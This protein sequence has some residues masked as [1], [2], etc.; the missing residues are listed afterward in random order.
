MVDFIYQYFALASIG[1]LLA[2]IS[3]FYFLWISVIR[4]RYM[5]TRHHDSNDMK[6]TPIPPPEVGGAWPIIGHL[7]QLA[8]STPLFK[9]LGDMADKYGS[10]FMVWF[11][12]YP[13]LVVSSW[14]M[15]KECFT[16]N[17]KF[18][19]S[20]PPTASGKYLGYDFAML[21][22]AFYGPYWR[23]LRKISTLQLLSHKRLELL[24]HVTNSEIENCIK[25]LYQGWNKNQNQN[26]IKQEGATSGSFKV[27]M[28]RVF[29]DLT[30]N[31]VLKLVVG[32]ALYTED[33]NEKEREESQKLHETISE[34]FRLAGVTVASDAL[35]FLGRLDVDGQKKQ[36]KRIAKEMDLIAEKWLEEHRERKRPRTLLHAAADSS[37]DENDFM[38][39]LISV[40]D[41]AKDNL[42]Y[43]YSRDTVI[44]AT[45]L[46]LTLAASDTTSVSMTWA[47]S[48]LLTNPSVLQKAQEELDT[49]VGKDRNIQDHDINDLV[50]LQAI[51]KETLRLYPAGPLSV[52]HE[53]IEDCNIG[54]YKVKAGTRLLVNLWKLHRDP[55]VWSNPLEFK[56][57]RFLSELDGGTGGEAANL[58]FKGQNFEYTPFGSGRRM[59]PGL[60]LAIQTLH[61]SLACLLHAFDFDISTGLVIDMAEGSGLT[62]PKVTPLEVHLYPR[63]PS[64]LY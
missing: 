27:D 11:G 26:Q 45:Y 12:M 54:G 46:A 10:I 8:G 13:T 19:A 53:A 33:D 48:L 62:M 4:P 17:D 35:P 60:N 5:K 42:F 64:T 22:F 6:L 41:E 40:L 49:V 50:Y 9:I 31:T 57:E 30:L 28:T 44:K 23:E 56:P 21:G 61:M 20:R 58:D 59:C 39:V 38:D 25:K 52:P 1:G 36:M 24:K 16:I 29:G 63:L 2:C 34:F 14:E 18:L 32:K 7:P 37:N 51:I 3:F 55:R 47:L 43:D 15:S